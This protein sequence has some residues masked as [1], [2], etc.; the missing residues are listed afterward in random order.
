MRGEAKVLFNGQTQRLHDLI[1]QV[2]FDL[3]LEGVQQLVWGVV[4][5]AVTDGRNRVTQHREH[6]LKGGREGGREWRGSGNRGGA[7]GV[8]IF[9]KNP[10]SFLYDSQ[11]NVH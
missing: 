9:F 7:R 11:V 1:L 4:V 6:V 3:F 8:E 2:A 5:M 10:V